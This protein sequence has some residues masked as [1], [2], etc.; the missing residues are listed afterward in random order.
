VRRRRLLATVGS[1]GATLAA[2]C[3]STP[4]APGERER[5]L[6]VHDGRERTYLLYRPPDLAGAPR[7]LVVVLHGGGGTGAR[8]ARTTGFDVLAASAGFLV[9]YPDGVGGWN[10]GRETT[11][12]RAHREDVDDVGFLRTLVDRLG[13]DPAVDPRR[14]GLT[15]ISNG[16]MMTLRVVTEAPGT[17]A[18]AA[19]VNASLPVGADRRPSTPVP[20]L[21]FHGTADPLVPWDGGHVGFAGRH[22]DRG[23]VLSAEATVERLVSA[24]DCT[25]ADDRPLPDRARDG[26]RV[27]ERRYDGCRSGAV[28]RHVVVHR[29]GHDWPGADHGPLDL[30]L[31][32]TTRDVDAT[33]LIWRFFAE[34]FDQ[35]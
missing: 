10:D 5:R 21:L 7:P 33:R 20:V 23:R 28:V 16:G 3:G 12:Q 32:T 11:A 24:F 9:A 26:T 8:V 18:A 29:G 14:V 30:L 34:R 13:D 17:V 31:G 1:V 2:G 15:G 4:D 6:L 35:S 25:P 22:A 27:T 19:S